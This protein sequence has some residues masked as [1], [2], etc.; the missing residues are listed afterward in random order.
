MAEK[1]GKDIGSSVNRLGI[2][3]RNQ[4]S[5][6]YGQ[7]V[8]SAITLVFGVI[9]LLWFSFGKIIPKS[10]GDSAEELEKK[11]K[12]WSGVFYGLAILIIISLSLSWAAIKACRAA[13]AQR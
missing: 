5:L 1:V 7:Y 12:T 6:E 4:T 2:R 13:V 10:E 3:E 11:Q 9:A 8:F